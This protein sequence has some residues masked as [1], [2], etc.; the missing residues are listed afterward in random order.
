[1]NLEKLFIIGLLLTFMAFLIPE[2]VMSVE[3]VTG[4][5]APVLNA[6]P[7]LLVVV[8]IGACAWYG[9]HDE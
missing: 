5:L 4:P 9:V 6:I 1:M 7:V 8:V 2:I 3:G